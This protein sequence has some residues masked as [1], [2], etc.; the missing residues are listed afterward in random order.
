MRYQAFL[1]G[2]AAEFDVYFKSGLGTAIKIQTK[3]IVKP[4]IEESLT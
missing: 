4:N 2:K 3:L 1:N